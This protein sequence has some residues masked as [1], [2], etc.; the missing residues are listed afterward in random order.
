MSSNDRKRKNGRFIGIPYHIASSEQFAKLKAP[1][2]KL[3]IDLLTQYNGNNNGMLSPCYTLMK[4][5]NWARSSLYRAYAD[6]VHSGFIVVTR[7]GMKI[8]GFPTLVAITWNSVDEPIKCSFDVDV[9][10]SPVPLSFW[11]RD[12]SQ[13]SIEPH[14]KP[15]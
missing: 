5:R 11:N 8:R 15:P 13:W 12:K 3:I 9:K 1:S 7:Q 4:K 14:I 6:L 10:I 2:V